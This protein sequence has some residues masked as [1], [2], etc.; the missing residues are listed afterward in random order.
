MKTENTAME[1]KDSSEIK[2]DT[3]QGMEAVIKI[4]RGVPGKREEEIR[5][6]HGQDLEGGIQGLTF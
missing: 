1:V 3:R 4:K 6:S 5:G 2:R